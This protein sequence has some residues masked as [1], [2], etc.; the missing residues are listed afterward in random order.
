MSCIRRMSRETEVS[1]VNTCSLSQTRDYSH[2]QHNRDNGCSSRQNKTTYH[3]ATSSRACACQCGPAIVANARACA[4]SKVP[5][6]RPSLPKQARGFFVQ[7]Y[8]TL[9]SVCLSPVTAR[10]ALGRV[11][12]D[13]FPGTTRGIYN[14]ACVHDF[15]P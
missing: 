14:R 10:S 8:D 13:A 1:T 3:L 9:S 5:Y 11:H 7:E 4:G 2:H 12:A 15:C 6:G